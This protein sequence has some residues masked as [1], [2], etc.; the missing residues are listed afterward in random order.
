MTNEPTIHP[1]SNTQTHVLLMGSR[2]SSRGRPISQPVGLT[3]T[4]AVKLK[5]KTI[6]VTGIYKIRP[7]DV[8]TFVA[9]E[10]LI[11]GVPTSRQGGIQVNDPG[12]FGV[13]ST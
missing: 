12:G 9:G 8:R 7:G 5:R 1:A 6:G 4:G 13:G 2:N 10:W 11:D 3:P